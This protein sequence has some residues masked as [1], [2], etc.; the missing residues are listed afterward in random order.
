MSSIGLQTALRSALQRK[1]PCPAWGPPEKG[2]SWEDHETYQHW[3]RRFTLWLD[4]EER[5]TSP[6]WQIART[7]TLAMKGAAQDRILDQTDEELYAAGNATADPP[8]LPGYMLALES[9]DDRFWGDTQEQAKEAY[10]R[11]KKVQRR[12]GQDMRTFVAEFERRFD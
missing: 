7:F 5:M 8:V 2:E 12:D 11:W 9:L 6:S 3:R 1:E 10:Q 4:G